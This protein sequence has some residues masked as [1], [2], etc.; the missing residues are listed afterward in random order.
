MNILTNIEGYK[1]PNNITKNIVLGIF[2]TYYFREIATTEGNCSYPFEEL[3]GLYWIDEACDV[4]IDTVIEGATKANKIIFLID[5][6][7]PNITGDEDSYTCK[8]L[9]TLLSTP[10]IPLNKIVFMED[11]IVVHSDYV[12]EKLNLIQYKE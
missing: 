7:E 9:I 12:L 11:N 5:G 10:S 4:I 8:E 2:E 1:V 6:L 3:I